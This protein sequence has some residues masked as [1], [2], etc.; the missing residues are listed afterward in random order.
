MHLGFILRLLTF[1][2]VTWA[3]GC[4]SI[5]PEFMFNTTFL[6]DP[7]TF[8][9]GTQVETLS[10]WTCRRSEIASLFATD[11]LGS[12]PPRPPIF[13]ASFSSSSSTLSITSA[14]SNTTTPMTFHTT[15]TYPSSGA[16]PSPRSSHSTAS[17]SQCPPPSPQSRSP[18]PP[19][20]SKTRSQAAA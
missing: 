7:F 1:L 20:C 6:P 11:E 19:S 16:P 4:P 13:S 10:D 8:A 18:S 12:K 17:L 9:D 15:I 14:L 3:L 5:P 2:G